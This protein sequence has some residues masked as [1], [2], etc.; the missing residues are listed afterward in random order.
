MLKVWRNRIFKATFSIV[1]KTSENPAADPG[2]AAW[3]RQDCWY[4]VWLRWGG[5]PPDCW[6]VWQ[7]E[8]TLS[9]VSDWKATSL[10]VQISV[11][12][13]LMHINSL[14]AC[15]DCLSKSIFRVTSFL[16][17]TSTT[18]WICC[19][20][21]RQRQRMLRLLWENGTLWRA[22]DPLSLL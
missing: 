5:L 13:A 3:D 18:S 11:C 7:G 16:Q 22:L 9:D 8:K 21:V 15:S 6:T 10:A 19:G 12:V 1:S 4:P 20:F 14:C 17:T 2:E